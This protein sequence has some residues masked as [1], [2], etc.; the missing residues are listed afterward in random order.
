MTSNDQNNHLFN[1]FL[2][3]LI[4]TGSAFG[5]INLASLQSFEEVSRDVQTMIEEAKISFDFTTLL[6]DPDDIPNNQDGGINAL[7]RHAT[8]ALLNSQSGIN[9]P[10][11][12]EQVILNFYDAFSSGE[13]ETTKDM[14]AQFNDVHLVISE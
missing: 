8:A 4:G 7:V 12:S 5:F 9:Y 11:T 10:L 14:F 1:N 3:V 6:V 2:T 13:F